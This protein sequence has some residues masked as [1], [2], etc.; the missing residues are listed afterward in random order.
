MSLKLNILASWIAHVIMVAIGFYMVPYVRNTLPNGDYGVWVF[1]NS[2]ASYSSLLYMGMGATVCRYVARY[3]TQ[4]DWD[5][6]NRFAS[7]VFS[8]FS[9]TAGIVMLAALGLS[10]AAPWIGRFGTTPIRDVQCVILLNGLSTSIGMVGAVFGGA[11][12]GVQRTGLKR[13]IE[14]SCGVLRFLLVLACLKWRPALTT[15]SVLFCGITVLENLL[16]WTSARRLIPTLQIRRSLATRE[17]FAEC[18]GFS[19]YTALAQIAEQLIYVTDTVVIGLALGTGQIEPYYFALRICQMIQEPLAILG[20]VVLPRASEL[21]ARGCHEDLARVIYR[22]AALSFMLVAGFAI[23]ATY[24]GGM[25]LEC[26]IGPGLAQSHRI[27]II[28]IAAQ[29]VS[30]PTLVLRRTMV[31]MGIVKVPA[32]IDIAEAVINLVLSLILV[33]HWGIEG[34]AWGTFFPLVVIELLVFLPFAC[35][36]IGIRKRDLLMN[37]IVPCLLP[38]LALWGYS[39]YVLQQA[40]PTGWVT[41][42]AIAAGGAGVLGLTGLPALWL[43]RREPQEA[44][45][46]PLPVPQGE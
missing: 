8:I 46:A 31:G 37:S 44:E 23:G 18:F 41:L 21:H 27:L 43:L 20:E 24:F 15:L 2:L 32:L 36:A 7:T 30:Q 12:I 40:F 42:I 3:H 25:L 33:F 22:L 14:V 13:T 26:W 10:V 5:T 34:V 9:G 6:L 35:Q 28:L 16:L 45:P 11:L 38:L 39:H 19:G 1:V 29:V 4:K 17:S